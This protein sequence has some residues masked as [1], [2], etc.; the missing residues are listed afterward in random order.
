MALPE[1]TVQWEAFVAGYL[2]HRFDLRSNAEALHRQLAAAA[3]DR[4]YGAVLG[5]RALR[6]A[7]LGGYAGML[8]RHSFECWGV[9]LYLCLGK[10]DALERLT[11][12]DNAHLRTLARGWPESRW[13]EDLEALEAVQSGGALRISELIE[14]VS[15][16][17]DEEDEAPLLEPLDHY[18][19]MFRV[20]S[21]ESAHC[22]LG[23][24]ERHV[25]WEGYV[26]L[27]DDGGLRG[28]E[29]GG[30]LTFALAYAAD[31]AGFVLREFGMDPEPMWRITS[32]C[33]R[34]FEADSP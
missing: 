12:S 25:T 11:A 9:G 29:D 14:H 20:E 30:Q 10:E 3:L 18:R 1:P 8:V 16:L 33:V 26:V 19:S 5:I 31:L 21:R 34:L 13:H 28:R 27:L 7:D 6:G 24:L 23:A 2:S 17:L 32:D 22:G 4:S 15:E